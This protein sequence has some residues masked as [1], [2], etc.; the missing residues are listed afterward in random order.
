MR[1]SSRIRD[2]QEVR[3]A[4]SPPPATPVKRKTPKKARSKVQQPKPAVKRSAPKPQ[5]PKVEPIGQLVDVLDRLDDNLRLLFHLE[6]FVSLVYYDPAEAKQD[7]TALYRNWAQKH[8]PWEPALD[9]A[10]NRVARRAIQKLKDEAEQII[11]E[12]HKVE[13]PSKKRKLEIKEEY[14]QARESEEP[15]ELDAEDVAE[16]H[17]AE[18]EDPEDAVKEEYDV[19]APR[20]THPEHLTKP[21]FSSL[22]DLLNSYKYLEDDQTMDPVKWEQYVAD[23]ANIYFKVKNAER[24]GHLDEIKQ[25]H[26]EREIPKFVD[27]GLTPTFQDNLVAQAIYLAKYKLNH[28]KVY[29]GN[30]RKTA[31]NIEQY[32]KRLAGAAEREKK[33][34]E[35]ELRFTARKLAQLVLNQWKVALKVVD[36]RKQQAADELKK[37]RG[38]AYL[39][40][41]LEHSAQLLENQHHNESLSDEMDAL[42]SEAESDANQSGKEDS[43]DFSSASESEEEGANEDDKL[44]VEQLREKYGVP[45]S[46][47]PETTPDITPAP[48]A[49]LASE[50]LPAEPPA[51]GFTEAEA[52]LEPTSETQD[53]TVA[54]DSLDIDEE[55]I[56]KM[57]QLY[58]EQPED[59]ESD[60]DMSDQRDDMEDS[61]DESEDS[62][63][64]EGGS[65]LSMLYS[66]SNPKDEDQ[67]EEFDA[68]NDSVSSPHNSNDDDEKTHMSVDE[69]VTVGVQSPQDEEMKP[70]SDA[71]A[72]QAHETSDQKLDEARDKDLVK[73]SD[74]DAE[75]PTEVNEPETPAGLDNSQLAIA[76]EHSQALNHMHK[77]EPP[78]LLRG[79]LREYQR[80]GLD[81]LAGLY[82]TQTNGILADEMGLGKTIQTIALLAWLA[83]EKQVWGPHLIVVPTSVMLNWEM[84]FKRFAPGLKVMTYYGNPQQRKDKRRGWNKEDTWHVCIT[85]YQLVIQDQAAF[86]RKRWKYMILDEAHNIKNF[87]SQR[88][89]ALLNFN[90]ERRLLLTGTPLQ[91][92]LVELWS[93]LYFLMPSS[94][95]TQMM[96]EGFANLEDFQ[97]WFSRPVNQMVEE[98]TEADQETRMTI[99]KLHQVLRPYILRRLKVDVETQMPGKYEHVISCKLSKRQRYLYDDFMS[100]AQTKETLASGNFMSIL[101]CLMQLRKVCNHPDLFEVRPIKTSLAIEHSVV[102]KDEQLF[103]SLEIGSGWSDSVSWDMLNLILPNIE[104]KSSCIA[105]IGVV[106]EHSLKE[107][108]KI[109]EYPSPEPADLTDLERWAKYS[110][111]RRRA[112]REEAKRHSKYL[113]AFMARRV[114][115]YGID[116][117]SAVT[118]K[119]R[120]PP[121]NRP[122]RGF[123]WN[124]KFDKLI[125][126]IEDRERQLKDIITRYSF[127]TPEVISLDYPQLQ[128][129]DITRTDL[130]S[131]SKQPEFHESQVRLSIQ[132]PDKR[133]LQYD[134]GKLQ[135]MAVL[136]RDLIANGHR[137]LIFTQMTRVLDILEQFLN[138]HGWRYL[139]LDGA[140]RVEQRQVLTER[141]NKDSSIPVFILS[142]RSGGLGINLTGADTVIFYDSDWNPAMDKQCQD[143]CH[144]IGQ[145]R[146]V[147]IYRLVSEYT[148][149]SNILKKATQKTILDNVVIQE[150]DF[151]TDYFKRI[152]VREILGV[153]SPEV[154]SAEPQQELVAPEENIEAALAQAEDAD[155]IAA[156]HMALSEARLDAEEFGKQEADKSPSATETREVSQEPEE[157]IGH[158]DDYMVRLI[159]RGDFGE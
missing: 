134:C 4:P 150:G 54:Q 19:P 78:F 125:Y 102:H 117:R 79:T 33:D 48:D 93:L 90:S 53:T 34:Q 35:K 68:A 89:Q 158:V 106:E 64:Q 122:Q 61:E 88:W 101:N 22:D 59:E 84:E 130:D 153:P 109:N 100:R 127:V 2:H 121:L 25:F 133:L 44:T 131:F 96:P 143:R 98:G 31:Q 140:T 63:G 18:T 120:L 15:E 80:D 82:N 51:S 11:S 49:A 149:E 77:I 37:I 135:K 148:I 155:D 142:T 136:L 87:R 124:A 146:D 104:A 1:R 141:F 103:K 105:N 71:D 108:S 123:N 119:P 30:A 154:G 156:A 129:G 92:N 14:E 3:R 41:I 8:D 70:A 66:K 67:D 81:W 152:S 21:Q 113:G 56:A 74:E 52:S 57:K 157:E 5:A 26:T 65:L 94:K 69:E 75:S 86:K 144:R 40:E 116:V 110:V 159:M 145:T 83:C 72:E 20:Y 111:E 42:S 46:S 138:I 114:P 107:L 23:E 17:R 28:R 151:T 112:E 91:N 36:L 97:E 24:S 147:H 39:N 126:G 38:K 10:P 62:D 137:I 95:G 118:M 9:S 6:K 43:S 76:G 73:H 58:D 55:A 7:H 12:Q 50:E 16:E 47:A 85:S 27:P 29:L 45:D 139:R 115:V 32:L 13:R 99:S 128:A 60:V 132:F